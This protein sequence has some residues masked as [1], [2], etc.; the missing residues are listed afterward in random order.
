MT[1]HTCVTYAR[2]RGRRRKDTEKVRVEKQNTL[3]SL[4]IALTMT[5]QQHNQVQQHNQTTL[6]NDQFSDIHMETSKLSQT[7]IKPTVADIIRQ[8]AYLPGG[9]I[10]GNGDGSA[11]LKEGEHLGLVVG[12]VVVTSDGGSDGVSGG[13]AGG[14]VAHS[15]DVWVG[16]LSIDLSSSVGDNPVEGVVHESTLASVVNGV[17]GH[18]H[19]LGDGD[20]GVS[21]K[22]PLSLDVSGSGERPAGSALALVLDV[23]DGTLGSPVDGA[24]TRDGG[25][26]HVGGGDGV[27]LGEEAL[28][29]VHPLELGAAQHK[30]LQTQR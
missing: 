6:Y 12:D 20:E 23:G 24:L 13:G 3:V 30:Y 14:H 15:G 19:L 26:V 18:E 5:F 16:G 27:S 17:T 2:D 10:N 11:L 29:A 1:E 21:G 8:R 9:G 25:L 22:L 7:N 4:C 28:T